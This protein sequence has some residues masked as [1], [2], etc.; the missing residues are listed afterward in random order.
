MIIH[1]DLSSDSDGPLDPTR[2]VGDSRIPVVPEVSPIDQSYVVK[3]MSQSNGAVYYQASP[4]ASK[5]KATGTTSATS[6][7]RQESL[8]KYI[9]VVD[10]QIFRNKTSGLL[11]LFLGAW[12]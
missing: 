12:Q 11:D 1:D 6:H 7:H 2:M 3:R 4:P 5:I 9:A 8:S 10:L